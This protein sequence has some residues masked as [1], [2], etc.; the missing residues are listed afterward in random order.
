MMTGREDPE[1]REGGSEG[2][3]RSCW[4]SCVL[5]LLQ[6]EVPLPLGRGFEVGL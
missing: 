1:K 3:L 4:G 2:K 5:C 6:A